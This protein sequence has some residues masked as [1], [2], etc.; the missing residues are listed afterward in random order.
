MSPTSYQAAPPRAIDTTRLASLLQPH[1]R[2]VNGFGTFKDGGKEGGMEGG[3]L[4]P[5]PAAAGGAYF[6]TGLF[7]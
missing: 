7:P 6:Q 5:V 4:A 2:Q 3:F 1:P